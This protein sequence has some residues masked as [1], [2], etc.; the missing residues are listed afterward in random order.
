[1]GD[2]GAWG[3][4]GRNALGKVSDSIEVGEDGERHSIFDEGGTGLE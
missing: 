3:F 2:S 4:G 1:M